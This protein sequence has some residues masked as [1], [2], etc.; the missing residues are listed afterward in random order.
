M[1]NPLRRQIDFKLSVLVILAAVGIQVHAQNITFHC[2]KP[3]YFGGE[4]IF[5][6]LFIPF[7]HTDS[8]CVVNVHL[9]TGSQVVQRHYLLVSKS[10][11]TGH[12]KL[13]YDLPSDI[14]FIGADL[15]ESK[16][17]Q[18]EQIFV[19][20][21]SIYN[22]FKG[23]SGIEFPKVE[24]EGIQSKIESGA[25]TIHL[26]NRILT[27][28][29]SVQCTIKV[30]QSSLNNSSITLSIA[31]RNKSLYQQTGRTIISD[32]AIVPSKSWI[33]RIP[34]S[35]R[36]KLVSTHAIN[37]PLMGIAFSQGLRFEVASVRQE[38]F[39]AAI[40]LF[41]GSQYVEFIDYITDD[42]SIEVN[43]G[44]R[45]IHP[46][47]A[48]NQDHKI[49]DQL[50]LYEKRKMIYQLYRTVDIQNEIIVNPSER[51]Q[52]SPNY[53]IDVKDFA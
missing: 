50:T 21:I 23:N 27:T 1:I 39:Q 51:P 13:P 42:F 31:I 24:F 10:K 46:T 9:G 7:I 25:I 18:A 45:P 17:N 19:R 12:F 6:N 38:V 5:F 29:D 44:P 26:P 41:Y 33:D 32:L 52:I 20:P 53:E 47:V 3:Y 49:S 28:R 40:P 16:T 35:G 22:T 36:R 4:F 34:I 37:N 8:T 48:F 30:D 14:Y 11:A 15:I 43:T 2:D